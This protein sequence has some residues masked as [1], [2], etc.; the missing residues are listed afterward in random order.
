M[1]PPYVWGGFVMG[2]AIC[3]VLDF[4]E[5]FLQ[6]I[7]HLLDKWE[8]KT[9]ASAIIAVVLHF[10]HSPYGIVLNAYFWLV[11]LDITTKWLAI[12]YQVLIDKGADKDNITT[13]EK[14]QGIVIAFDCKV[15]KSNVMLW[16]F[17]TKFILFTILITT[18]YQTDNVLNAIEIPLS[19]PVL[20]FVFGYICYN[21][22]L[23]ICE[24]LRDAG[25]KHLDQLIDL[26]NTN[27]FSKLKR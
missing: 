9:I 14:V 10:I 3:D 25:N 26:L 17:M 20:K 8:V 16:G 27:I 13:W 18:A 23:S 4:I 21:E 11:I 6:S 22:L 24:N 12:G 5:Y 7:M 2:C 15:L 1:K 19:F